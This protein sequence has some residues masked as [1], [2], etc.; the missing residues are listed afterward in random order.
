MDIS[1]PTPVEFPPPVGQVCGSG[2]MNT[3]DMESE[4]RS[5]ESDVLAKNVVPLVFRSNGK[6]TGEQPVVREVRATFLSS[7]RRLPK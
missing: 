4:I 1:R 6:P 3:D 5:V 2:V 7:N